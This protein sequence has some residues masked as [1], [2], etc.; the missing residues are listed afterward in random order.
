M[1]AAKRGGSNFPLVRIRAA[2]MAAEARKQH[3]ER[4]LKKRGPCYS[5][6]GSAINEKKGGERGLSLKERGW[7]R[8][9]TTG[10]YQAE[11][12]EGSSCR[13]LIL[14]KDNLISEEKEGQTRK[15][16]SFPNQIPLLIFG[17]RKAL[18]ERAYTIGLPISSNPG[19]GGDYRRRSERHAEGT[20]LESCLIVAGGG[21]REKLS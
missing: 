13:R 19:K 8:K 14:Q 1:S 7:T 18:C 3:A 9:G 21:G 5:Q 6:R 4:L 16:A 17:G 11:K 15:G 10:H 20:C 2:S 12:G